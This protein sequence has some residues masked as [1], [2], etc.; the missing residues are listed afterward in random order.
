ML[1]YTVSR[2]SRYIG[3]EINSVRKDLTEGRIKIVL[4]FPDLYE[5]GVSHSGLKILYQILNDRDDAAVERA[6]AP[7]TD[8]E[9][10]MIRKNMPLVS[11]ESALPIREFD[12]IGFTLPYELTFTNILNILKLSDIPL[13]AYDRDREY[14]LI[15]GGGSS[16]FNPE[17]LADFFDAFILG[18]G[19]DVV[20]EVV[21]IYQEWKR[22]VG[23]KEEILKVLARIE[24][25]YVP[26]L[27]KICY[28]GNIIDSVSPLY[29]APSKVRRR[30]VNDLNNAQYADRPVLPY[31]K[32]VHDRFCVEISRGCTHGCRFC[33]AGIIY[34]PV[35]D[36]SMDNIEGIID[37]GLKYTGYGDVSLLSLSSGDY[38]CIALLLTR[39]MDKY[40]K[41]RVSF[42][43]P[44]LRVGTLTPDVL[45]QIKRVKRSGFTLAPEAGTNK[46]RQVINKDISDDELDE[47]TGRLFKEGWKKIKFYFMIGLPTEEDKD[48]QGIIDLCRRVNRRRGKIKASIS[49]FVPKAHTPF[50]WLGQISIEE[51]KRRQR[52]IRDELKG[53][54]IEVDTHKPDVSHIEAV[55]SRGDR[56][57]GEVLR[58]TMEDGSRFDGWTD[59][60][61]FD[62]WRRIFE[63]T[64][65]DSSFY[66]CRDIDIK[67]ILPWEHL[68]TGVT[69]DFLIAEL[70]N[71]Y[72]GTTT[73]DCRWGKCHDC[74]V[75]IKKG[76]MLISPV[77][78]GGREQGAENGNQ[79]LRI[80]DQIKGLPGIGY[81]YRIRFSK[82][83]KLRFLSHLE[84]IDTISRSLR[85]TGLPLSFSSGFT[86]HIEISFGPALSV[87]V[88]S[89]SEYMDITISQPIDPEY[90]K[91]VINRN[92]PDGICIL[93]T[94]RILPD[95]NSLSKIISGYSYEIEV[96]SGLFKLDK[97]ILNRFLI[98]DEILVNKTTN[99]GK[100]VVDVRP[101][102]ERCE[103]MTNAEKRIFLFL[104]N[105]N[106]NICRPQDVL[107]GIIN[108]INGNEKSILKNGDAKVTRT[109]M[110]VN[111]DG[112]WCKP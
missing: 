99:R 20:N 65:I 54:K 34:R 16:V 71:A 106:N 97:Q 64:G 112:Q 15:I 44:S 12:I 39:L 29:P 48:L 6:Y 30:I 42:S 1:K 82:E 4:I 49:T 68:D 63:K 74:G 8:Y 83:G 69:R 101:F 11:L 19:E 32:A 37:K 5:I 46:L 103:L 23:S 10:M 102:I 55:L 94:R 24:G 67:E 56:R 25:V 61:S 22:D 81:R 66:A 100:K 77:S 76:D 92:M 13:Y 27:Y 105:Q 111:R 91:E 88:E 52:F 9:E 26:S 31:T 96:N 72:S 85:R 95:S 59:I 51:I 35:R 33:Q 80:R 58:L 50:Q 75:C 21:D 86:P 7:W 60:F 109:G 87:G 2:P 3:G 84:L 36:R 110:Y 28:R 108:F 90:I 57:L 93:E 45:E 98:M 78:A 79:G 89:I 41:D 53:I 70:H 17:P 73:S 62:R 104:K 18:D 40:E 14:P 43:L 107:Q 47:I 38:P